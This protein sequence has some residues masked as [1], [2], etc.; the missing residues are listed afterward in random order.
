MTV[1][2]KTLEKLK[3]LLIANQL[4]VA[5]AESLTCGR[6]Q[7]VLGSI[8]GASNFFEGGITAYSLRQK[9][10]LLAV[11]RQHAKSV[12]SV[13]QRVAFELAGG[14][15]NLFQTDIGIGT[16]GYAEICPEMEIHQP[17]AYVG[18]S[19]RSEGKIMN[20]AGDYITGNGLNRVQMQEYVCRAALV[21]LL[22]YLENYQPVK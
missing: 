5:V 9:T 1:D 4:R 13:S 2:T 21:A 10:R 20:I 14:A 3:A 6:L 15:C 7:A 17:I 8:S 16:T 18:I 19:R 12:N 11:D 22:S